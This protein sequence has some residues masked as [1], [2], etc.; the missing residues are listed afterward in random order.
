MYRSENHPKPPVTMAKNLLPQAPR[1]IE[2]QTYIASSNHAGELAAAM[3][4]QPQ[5][6]GYRLGARMTRVQNA[7]DDVAASGLNTSSQ[8]SL[9]CHI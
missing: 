2:T 4:Y 8:T 9:S 7:L 5:A 3:A 1:Y 6:S